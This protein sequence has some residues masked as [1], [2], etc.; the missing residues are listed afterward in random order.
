MEHGKKGGTDMTWFEITGNRFAMTPS[1]VVNVSRSLH[2][3][4]ARGWMGLQV[5]LNGRRRYLKV[6]PALPYQPGQESSR[7]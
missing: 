7:S 1:V 3:V 6:L 5:E 2:W 4:K